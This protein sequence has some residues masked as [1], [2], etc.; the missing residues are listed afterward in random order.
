MNALPE[1]SKWDCLAERERERISKEIA[2]I[3]PA[4]RFCGVHTYS[5]GTQS[6]H[7]A[8]FSH[9][10][11]DFALIPGGRATLGYDRHH[12]WTPSDE[13]RAIWQRSIYDSDEA[14]AELEE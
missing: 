13:E 3:Y 11:D 2:R 1:L 5:Q 10:D 9:R 8:Q 14:D 4:F 12:P 6:H 7:V